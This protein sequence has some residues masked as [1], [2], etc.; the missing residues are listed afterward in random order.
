MDISRAVKCF[1]G[2]LTREEDWCELQI[3]ALPCSLE[4]QFFNMLTLYLLAQDLPGR[5]GV[6]ILENR[7]YNTV[8][9][10]VSRVHKV[11]GSNPSTTKP[12]LKT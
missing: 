11:L 6:L 5:K 3:L 10:Y 2:S 7:G 8:I 4:F 12:N 1:A 9:E